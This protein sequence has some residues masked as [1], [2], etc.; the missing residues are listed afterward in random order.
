M[1]TTCRTLRELAIW[2]HNTTG[3]TY[4]AE[5]RP[6][7]FPN[8]QAF[9]LLYN[10]GTGINQTWEACESLVSTVMAVSGPQ[11]IEFRLYMHNCDP[12]TILKGERSFIPRFHPRISVLRLYCWDSYTPPLKTTEAELILR[13]RMGEGRDFQVFWSMNWTC[14]THFGVPRGL[15]PG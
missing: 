7:T 15:G 13:E 10:G 8:L 4:L 2:V 11:L 14:L 1:G 5:F 6:L 12:S 9:T 3:E